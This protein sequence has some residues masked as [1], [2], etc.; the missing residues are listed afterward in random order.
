MEVALSSVFT[1]KYGSIIVI[2]DIS[3]AKALPLYALRQNYIY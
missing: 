1:V 3:Y 2:D